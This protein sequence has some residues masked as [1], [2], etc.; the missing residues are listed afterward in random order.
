MTASERTSSLTL[1]ARLGFSRLGEAESL[2]AELE[3]DAGIARAA[4]LSEA[5]VAADPDE[6]L[7]G[8]A[9]IARR[10]AAAVGAARGIHRIRGLL[11]AAS[12]RTHRARR[13]GGRTPHIRRA[14]CFAPRRD[15]RCR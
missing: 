9:R 13:R 2:L 6:A 1:L 11:S 8:L 7:G 12:G 3:A 5:A 14:A 15:R 4:A 10:D